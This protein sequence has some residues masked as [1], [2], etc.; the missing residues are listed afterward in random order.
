MAKKKTETEDIKLD[1]YMARL[2]GEF[3]K[4]FGEQVFRT[5][6]DI[7]DNKPTIVKWTP[8]LDL[9]LGGGVPTGTVISISGKPKVGKSSYLLYLAGKMQKAGLPVFY[10][11][12][13][14]RMK[15]M[16]LQGIH[17]L[18]LSPEKFRV[19]KSTAEKILTAQDFLTICERILK[20][21]PRCFI[22]LDSM[23]CLVEE[24]E[25]NEGLGTQTRGGQAKLVSQFIS[26]VAQTISATGSV[27]AGVNHLIAN[28]SG[29]GAPVVE[30]SSNRWI[31]SSDIQ[32]RITNTKEL[33]KGGEGTEVVGQVVTFKCNTSAL[34]K[35]FGV[36]ESKLRFGYGPDELAEII[37]LAIACGLIVQAGSWLKLEYLINESPEFDSMENCPKKQGAEQLWEFLNTKPEFVAILEAK[38]STYSSGLMKND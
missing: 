28:T 7:L 25:M 17:G 26:L 19:I 20:T 33:R 15:H 29:W 30:K 4:E 11:D 9:I 22:I 16:N 18:D 12:I 36:C 6:Q 14:G 8:A 31:Y 34:G 10:L 5:G 1:D 35:P 24:K 3:D 32:L 21:Y 2:K 38:L 27:I 37:D 23:S 13:E